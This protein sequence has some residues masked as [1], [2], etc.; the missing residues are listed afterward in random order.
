MRAIAPKSLYLVTDSGMTWGR[1]LVEIVAAAVRGGVGIVQLREKSLPTRAF[2]DLASQ[3]VKTL[4]GT[5]VPLLINDRVDVALAVGADGVH[6]GQS[7]M[8]YHDARKLL[9]PKAII[10]LSVE[11]I[12]DVIEAENYDVDYLGVSPVFSTLTKTDTIIEWGLDGLRRVRNMSRHFLVA[13]GRMTAANAQ[14]V[15]AAGADSI[16]VVSA[17]CAADDPEK[18]ARDIATIL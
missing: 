7:D 1:P 9:G 4:S 2:I 14:D 11:S 6:L 13:I 15:L 8:H 3:L 17:I 5:S 12:E 18:A 16:A 10:G